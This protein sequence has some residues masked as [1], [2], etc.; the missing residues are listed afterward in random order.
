MTNTITTTP[1]IYVACLAAYNN[2]RL[3]G[4]WIDAEQNADAIQEEIQEMLKNSPEP[5][6]E[7]WAIHD[8]EGFE[9]LSINEYESIEDVAE[10]ARLIAE[11]GAAYAAYANN[12]GVDYATEEGF[13]ESYQGE[14]DSEE[15]FAEN[16][17]DEIMDIP[18][19]LSYYFDYGKF[20]HELFMGDYY[21]VDNDNHNVYVFSNI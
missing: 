14:W 12:V 9:G 5:F 6:A 3:H 20:A 7:E 17:A 16:L 21:S 10:Y 8:Y 11:H 4:K 1:K 13:E 2:G 19:R 18:E 15:A